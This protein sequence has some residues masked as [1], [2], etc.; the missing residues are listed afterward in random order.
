MEAMSIGYWEQVQ[1]ADFEVPTSLNYDIR[2]TMRD[3]I[4]VRTGKG[5]KVKVG[6]TLKGNYTDKLTVNVPSGQIDSIRG[7]TAV[8]A[9]NKRTTVRLSNVRYNVAVP[10]TAFNYAEPKKS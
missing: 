10:E 6:K 4:L 5:A 8:D 2:L 9:Q 3:V 1:A 7:W